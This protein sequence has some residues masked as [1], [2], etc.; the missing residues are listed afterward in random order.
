[1]RGEV[2]MTHLS[3]EDLT[4]LYCGEADAETHLEECG[5]C[6]GRYDSLRR[7]LEAVELP[8]PE[9]GS[10]YG[11]AVWNRIETRIAHRRPRRRWIAP[12]AAALILILGGAFEAGRVYQ[13]RHQPA[14]PADSRMAERILFV[15]LGDYLERSQNVLI[16]LANADP[17]SALDISLDQVRA[18]DL[19]AENRLYRQTAERTG[20][21][22]IASL[23]EELERVLLEIEHEPSTLPPEDLKQLRHRLRDDG[24]LFKMRVMGT[25]VEKL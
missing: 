4:L 14:P 22:A 2:Q 3:D 12:V 7:V 18:R 10:E 16:E 15:A 9:R 21:A 19:V 17:D 20:Q 13:A 5:E 11:S 1:M 25:N 6:R 24:I 23:L 8:V